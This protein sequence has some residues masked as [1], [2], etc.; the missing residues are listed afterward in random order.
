MKIKEIILCLG[1]AWLMPSTQVFSAE[2]MNNEALQELGIEHLSMDYVLKCYQWL[3]EQES[4]SAKPVTDLN[5]TVTYYGNVQPTSLYKHED[6]YFLPTAP[7]I[8]TYNPTIGYDYI[9]VAYSLAPNEQIKT[10]FGKQDITTCF[11]VMQQL[12]EDSA[13]QLLRLHGFVHGPDAGT[14]NAGVSVPVELINKDDVIQFSNGSSSQVNSV[15]CH[16]GVAS[17]DNFDLK[18]WDPRIYLNE[19]YYQSFGVY[20]PSL[21]TAALIVVG[22][23][24]LDKNMSA[25]VGT[26]ILS[27]EAQ[28]HL[29][30]LLS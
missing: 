19:P 21:R 6:I 13:P 5:K 9:D 10:F 12:I 18:G 8:H 26:P 2:R 4:L 11:I 1:L 28:A 30:K 3:G 7:V 23:N 15:H 17:P 16:D 29:V 14:K 25:K 20:L 24:I 27:D 22:Q